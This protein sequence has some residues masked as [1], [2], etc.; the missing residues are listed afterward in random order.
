MK[1]NNYGKADFMIEIRYMEHSSWQGTVKWLDG[2]REDCFRSTLE[3]LKIMESVEQ[4]VAMENALP[5][6]ESNLRRIVL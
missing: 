3:L 2:E 1:K 5:E 6:E 4:A